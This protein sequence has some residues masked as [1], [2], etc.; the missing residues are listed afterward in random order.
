MVR[1]INAVQLSDTNTTLLF[2]MAEMIYEEN[3][4]HLTAC[5]AGMSVEDFGWLAVTLHGPVVDGG[6]R[7]QGDHVLGDPLPEDD[8]IR[9]GVGFHLRLHLDVEYL[10]SLL[11]LKSNDFAGR[12]HD[13]GVRADGPPDGIGRVGHVDDD[14]LGRLPD[15]LP[16]TDELVAL[17]GE[18]VEPDVGGVDP[19]IC[20]LK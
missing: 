5:E 13:G 20:E 6:L 8:V 16:D 12:V 9:H 18:G 11:G 7:H 17:H 3:C 19:D 2:P 15:L 1:I 4:S 10:Q 14:H